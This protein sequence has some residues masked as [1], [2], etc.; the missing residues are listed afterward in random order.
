MVTLLVKNLGI[1]ENILDK[2]SGIKDDLHNDVK[3]LIELYEASELRVEGEEIL[4]R[5]K[6]FTLNSLNELCSGRESHE[7]RE[8]MS[9]LAQPRHKTLR[10]L[11]SKR[12]ISMIKIA[13]EVDNEWLESLLRVAEI[14][15]TM[16]KSLIQEETSQTFK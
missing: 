5:V 9:S 3:G 8:I 7:D 11:T 12:F 13:G 14:D 16:L 2:K 15:S 4:D 1:F 10:R 6:E